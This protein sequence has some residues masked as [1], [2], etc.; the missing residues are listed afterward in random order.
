MTKNFANMKHQTIIKILAVVAVIAGFAACEL[1]TDH[2]PFN[3]LSADK[4]LEIE[5]LYQIYQDSGDNYKFTEDYMVYATVVMS[6]KSGNIYKEAYIQDETGG[7][8]LYRLDY[9]GLTNEGDYVRINLKDVAIKYY[10][11]KMELVFED[12]KDCGN[13]IIVQ[14]NNP[15]EPQDITID[16]LNTNNY[17]GEL[18]RINDVQ[19]AASDT[20]LTFAIFNGGSSQNRTLEDC[21]GASMIVRTSDYSDFATVQIPNGKGSIIGI[22]TTYIG[23][24]GD[25]TRQLLVRSMD[26]VLMDSPR[27]NE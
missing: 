5:D 26:E 2:P 25:V 21:N 10:S 27:C 12:V 24:N 19:F 6:D 20:S 7:I 16:S 4:I 3:T 13:Q 11:G 23:Y 9:S 22:A 14:E 15:L 18:V 17:E 8:N 1:E